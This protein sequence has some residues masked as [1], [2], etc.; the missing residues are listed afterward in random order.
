MT[1]PHEIT[2]IDS[3][4]FC[5]RCG[6]QLVTDDDGAWEHMV[7]ASTFY[8]GRSA[9]SILDAAPQGTPGT[10]AL[11]AMV[12]IELKRIADHLAAISE[13]GPR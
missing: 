8:V 12:V 1:E 11:L 9:Q 4:P 6:V 3:V 2:G 5:S 13:S 7:G 10:P